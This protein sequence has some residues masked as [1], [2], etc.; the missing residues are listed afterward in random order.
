M[1]Y[2]LCVCV[3]FFF[4]EIHFA[5]KT[6]FGNNACNVIL[7]NRYHFKKLLKV[8]EKKCLSTKN[9]IVTNTCTERQL[10]NFAS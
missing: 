6:C 3:V 10:W 8:Y 2:K 9:I 7:Y 5:A 4:K 1:Q